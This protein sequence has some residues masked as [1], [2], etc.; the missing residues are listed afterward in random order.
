MTDP[1]ALAFAN[2]ARATSGAAAALV[3]HRLSSVDVPT[4]RYHPAAAR[5]AVHRIKLAGFAPGRGAGD[6]PPDTHW[7]CGT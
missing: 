6:S 7:R 5:R 2:N 3:Y 1:P 4:A